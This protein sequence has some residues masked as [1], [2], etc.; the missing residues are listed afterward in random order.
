MRQLWR[1]R[2]GPKLSVY[3]GKVSFS[4]CLRNR[5]KDNTPSGEVKQCLKWPTHSPHLSSDISR[6]IRLWVPTAGHSHSQISDLSPNFQ[7]IQIKDSQFF[8]GRPAG[9]S[10]G[11]F[12]GC[13]ACTCRSSSKTCSTPSQSLWKEEVLGIMNNELVSS[14]TPLVGIEHTVWDNFIWI[15]VFVIPVSLLTSWS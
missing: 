3:W 10:I 12:A 5:K 2:R 8:V 9:R 15:E 1:F 7:L 4:S 13:S 11:S 14:P 6:L